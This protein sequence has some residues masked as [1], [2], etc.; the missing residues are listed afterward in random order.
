MAEIFNCLAIALIPVV[1][2]VFCFFA[3][4][5]GYQASANV[6]K[7]IQNSTEINETMVYNATPT[8]TPGKTQN[9]TQKISEIAVYNIIPARSP[10]KTQ[11]ITQKI[12]ETTLNNKTNTTVPEKTQNTT[13]KINETATSNK[14]NTT[15]PEKT[16]NTTQKINETI[17]APVAGAEAETISSPRYTAGMVI[18]NDDGHLQII[19]KC[20]EIT[21]EYLSRSLL[22]GNDGEAYMMK[23]NSFCQLGSSHNP[24]KSIEKVFPVLYDDLNT[25]N[26]SDYLKYYN[27]SAKKGA[28][29]YV[30][31]GTDVKGFTIGYL[32]PKNAEIMEYISENS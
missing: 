8:I 23:D 28:R 24:Y 1:L 21:G 29:I 14:T 31:A 26:S 9:I 7:E 19:T 16:Q 32:M 15:V 18:E 30:Y 12:S 22:M 17:P 6:L 5:T 13:Q 10:E 25:R 11:N 27:Y 3:G 20:N 2:L 4:C